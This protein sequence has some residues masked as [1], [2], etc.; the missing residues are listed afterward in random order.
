MLSGK[1]VWMAVRDC[2]GRGP[3]ANSI[4]G[5]AGL[6]V[7]RG[8]GCSAQ[9]ATLRAREIGY[10]ARV[11]RRLSLWGLE[12]KIGLVESQRDTERAEARGVF[13]LERVVSCSRF[14][15]RWRSQLDLGSGEPFDDLHGSATLGTAIKT[16][17][18]FG[19]GGVLFR[20][21]F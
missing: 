7:C 6:E 1:P 18:V 16:R 19:G 15:P 4:G 12:E 5:R 8:C 2:G 3:Y 17:S 14:D 13:A 11:S 10:G 20:L 21:W 9:P